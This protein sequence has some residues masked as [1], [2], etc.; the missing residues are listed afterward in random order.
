MGRAFFQR[1]KA[2]FRIRRSSGA[3][4]ELV[5]ALNTDTNVLALQVPIPS[6]AADVE[7]SDNMNQ[8][9]FGS[10]ELLDDSWVD[11]EKVFTLPLADAVIAEGCKQDN[12]EITPDISVAGVSSD[13]AVASADSD[14]ASSASIHIQQIQTS[15]E[16]SSMDVHIP[17]PSAPPPPPSCSPQ[18]SASSGSRSIAN[19]ICAMAVRFEAKRQVDGEIDAF[20]PS[21][22]HP[23]AVAQLE[24]ALATGLGEWLGSYMAQHLSPDDTRAQGVMTF[25]GGAAGSVGMSVLMSD[26][27]HVLIN[28]GAELAKYAVNKAVD[29]FADYMTNSAARDPQS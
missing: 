18:A 12:I 6:Q 23:E 4:R 22:S 17:T 10:G 2:C 16:S 7:L 13:A 21:D 3:C 26:G 25:V 28:A 8:M 19:E 27:H 11:N 1:A 14:F 29:S 9:K 5:P 24:V 20:C 15:R